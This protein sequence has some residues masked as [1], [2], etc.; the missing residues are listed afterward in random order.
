MFNT[1]ERP[2]HYVIVDKQSLTHQSLLFLPLEVNK[3]KKKKVKMVD[4][5]DSCP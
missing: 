1:G 4:P 2:F 3:Q 5:E